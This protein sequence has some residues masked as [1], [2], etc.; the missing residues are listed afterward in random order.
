LARIGSK[1]EL[2][3]GNT[4][5]TNLKLKKPSIAASR[6]VSRPTA[7]RSF[8]TLAV[9]QEDLAERVVTARS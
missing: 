4:A 3:A 1:L 2:S 9:P 5:G 8:G 7:L 6:R